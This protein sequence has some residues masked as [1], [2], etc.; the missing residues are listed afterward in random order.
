M[1]KCLYPELSW[2]TSSTISRK[3]LKTSSH[4]SLLSSSFHI[5]QCVPNTRKLRNATSRI[6]IYS[7]IRL[8]GPASCSESVTVEI[9]KVHDGVIFLC[10]QFSSFFFFVISNVHYWSENIYYWNTHTK[11]AYAKCRD[12]FIRKYPHSPVPTKSCVS[13]LI[14]K[15]RTTGSVL[16]KTWHRKKTVLTDE[17]LEDIYHKTLNSD[18]YVRHILEPF[19]EQLTDD[20]R[21]YGYYQQDNAPAHTA[22]NSI[23]ALQEVFDDR[24]IST[25]LW[26]PRS[27]DT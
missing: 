24:I 10:A 11:R 12:R 14:K 4:L 5:L 25:G 6:S 13:K 9:E 2:A 17:N 20:E 7:A 1:L 18:W 8:V 26:P 16:D 19:F 21:Q 27:Q 15:W 3:I 22:Q 23:S